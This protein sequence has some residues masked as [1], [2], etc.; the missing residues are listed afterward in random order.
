M[1]GEQSCQHSDFLHPETSSSVSESQAASNSTLTELVAE[2][3]FLRYGV[4]YSSSLDPVSL[5][6]ANPVRVQ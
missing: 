1:F 2:T 6:R 5:V 4:R 3:G